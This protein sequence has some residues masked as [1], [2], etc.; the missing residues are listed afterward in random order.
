M[1]CF[2]DG[3][4]TSLNPS[5]FE[6]IGLNNVPINRKNLINIL[7]GDNS[8]PKDVLWQNMKLRDQELKEHQEAVKCYNIDGIYA[9]HLTSC[10]DS[11][12]L[13]ICQLFNL[14]INHRYM[15]HLITYRNTTGERRVLNFSS[16]RGHFQRH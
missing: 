2:W 7:K 12:L 1:T 4:V 3:I 13:L 14:S 15:G 8:S 5:D 11:F 6:F 16:D 9:G 10:C